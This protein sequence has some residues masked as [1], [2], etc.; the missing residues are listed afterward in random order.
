M[1]SEFK[2]A[3]ICLIVAGV[4]VYNGFETRRYHKWY[5]DIDSSKANARRRSDDFRAGSVVWSTVRSIP[6]D[7]SAATVGSFSPGGYAR[8]GRRFSALLQCST[9][10]LSI[11]VTPCHRMQ[12]R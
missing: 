1:V 2:V 7:V 5:D 11:T 3:Q 10:M 6:S 12:S 4:V 8:L 9:I